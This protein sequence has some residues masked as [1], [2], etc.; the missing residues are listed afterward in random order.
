MLFCYSWIL[1][2]ITN[3]V[4]TSNHSIFFGKDEI[5]MDN[6][7]QKDQFVNQVQRP[8]SKDQTETAIVDDRFGLEECK[9]T[10][11]MKVIRVK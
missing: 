9:Y 6:H 10:T 11:V 1:I 5:M 8:G 2:I 4:N 3:E 7:I